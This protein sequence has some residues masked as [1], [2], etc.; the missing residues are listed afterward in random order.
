MKNIIKIAN[1]L[2]RVIM[3][4]FI[5][6]LLGTIFNKEI[7]IYSMYIAFV[8][9][10]YQLLSFLI[11]LFLIKTLNSKMKK[12]IITYISIVVFYFFMVFILFY[13]FKG[14]SKSISLITFFVSLPI[15]LSLFWTYI[16]ELINKEL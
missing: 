11:S 6:S 9:G 4:P 2:N 16:L 12:Q 3:I 14:S 8:L 10:I 15:C 7:F 5:L 13:N 1:W